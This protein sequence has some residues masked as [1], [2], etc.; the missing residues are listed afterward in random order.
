[1]AA[2]GRAGGQARGRNRALQAA[3]EATPRIDSGSQQAPVA[4]SSPTP[5]E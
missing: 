3:R 5:A 4:H 1:M 2:I